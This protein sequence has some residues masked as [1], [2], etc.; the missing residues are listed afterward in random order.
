LS[1]Y[2]QQGAHFTLI[3]TEKIVD[4]SFIHSYPHVLGVAAECL[5]GQSLFLFNRKKKHTSSR[6]GDF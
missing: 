6:L 3:W 1:V 5:E 2:A 4:I